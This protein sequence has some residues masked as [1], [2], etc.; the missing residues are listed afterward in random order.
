MLD[1]PFGKDNL[2][3]CFSAEPT[4][5]HVLLPLVHSLYLSPADWI[6]IQATN[7]T[8]HILATLLTEYSGVDFLSFQGY[9]NSWD[10]KIIDPDRVKLATAPLLHFEGDA[11]ALVCWAGGPHTG[12]HR[13]VDATITYP[14]GTIDPAILSNIEQSFCNVFQIHAMPALLNTISNRTLSWQPQQHRRGSGQNLQKLRQR[15]RPGL[16]SHTQRAHSAFCVKLSPY[17]GR[18]SQH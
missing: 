9:P 11:A 18:S 8:A 12:A 4:F 6:S 10:S 16:L 17:A 5:C 7:R 1:Q 14:A 2:S 15:S 13:D 3:Q